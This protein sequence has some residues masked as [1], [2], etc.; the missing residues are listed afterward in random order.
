M[1]RF[2]L[3]SGL[4][5]IVLVAGCASTTTTTAAIDPIAG[6]WLAST[7]YNGTTMEITLVFDDSGYFNGYFLG[8]L[9]MSGHW[10]KINTTAYDVC[11]GNRTIVFVMSGDKT[12]I[13]D[14]G[15]PEMIYSK[16]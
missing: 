15:H 6:N 12:G 4:V 8:S 3:L 16:L 2:L 7:T 9:A 11:Y 13:W 14:A 5:A 1:K 10:S